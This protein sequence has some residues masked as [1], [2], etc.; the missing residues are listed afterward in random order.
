MNINWVGETEGKLWETEHWTLGTLTPAISTLNTL[1]LTQL[2]D[3]KTEF[4]PASLSAA[5]TIGVSGGGR[6]GEGGDLSW[7]VV[8]GAGTWYCAT[9]FPTSNRY[10]AFL[11]Q[12]RSSFT[13]KRNNINCHN[14]GTSSPSV[15]FNVRCLLMSRFYMLHCCRDEKVSVKCY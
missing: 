7:Y 3:N 10:F 11:L 4:W 6:L 1:N 15:P 12:S 8:Q 9:R 13:F 2:T 5:M 14:R